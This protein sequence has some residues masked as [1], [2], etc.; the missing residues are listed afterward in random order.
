MDILTRVRSFVEQHWEKKGSLLVAY[1]GGPDSRALLEALSL[2]LPGKLEVAHVDHG[3]REESKSEAEEIRVE[4]EKRGI[5]CHIE[6]LQG[7]GTSNLEAKGRE[8][9][10]RFFFRL[11]RERNLEALCLGH[12]KE[13]LSETVCKRV[14]EGAHF[15]RWQ[16]MEE[17]MEREGYAVWR[18]L[19]SFSKK[20]IIKFLQKKKT[21]YLLDPTNRDPKFLRNRLREEI[22][23]SL[24]R[25]FGKNVQKSF[26]HLRR[27]S[28]EWES[29]LQETT[30]DL[31]WHKGVWGKAMF[32][33]GRFLVEIRYVLSKMGTLSR[34]CI[35]WILDSLSSSY[36]RRK[37]F[38]TWV[39]VSKGWIIFLENGGGALPEKGFH[40]TLQEELSRLL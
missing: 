39:I 12:Q 25:S 1:S 31:V 18:P 35:D 4:M 13:D 17:V 22:L 20:E 24:S 29:F 30:Q 3:W 9:R 37:F 33:Q 38:D 27:Q 11:L 2:C 23:P 19:L 21:P 7:K 40:A 8:A 10:Y 26:L 36:A 14:L 5:P 6:T 15:S 32:V 34:P 28:E 16:G